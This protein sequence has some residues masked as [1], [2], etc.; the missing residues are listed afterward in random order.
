MTGESAKSRIITPEEKSC[1]IYYSFLD[2]D[3]VTKSNN[4]N[5]NMVVCDKLLGTHSHSQSYRARRTSEWSY[6]MS[7]MPLPDLMMPSSWSLPSVRLVTLSLLYFVQGAPYGFQ[8]AC[9]P[10]ILREVR[11]LTF[12]NGEQKKRK[13][14]QQNLEK[15]Q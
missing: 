10:I 14:K 6:C 8:T 5:L 12:R 15:E 4:S 9:L 1:I 7:Q 11:W 13:E 3:K 2:V